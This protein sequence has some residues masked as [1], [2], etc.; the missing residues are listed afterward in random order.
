[1]THLTIEIRE[2]FKTNEL[3]NKSTNIRLYDFR[4]IIIASIRIL[5]TLIFKIKNDD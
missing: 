3:T 2:L 4:M 5:I 1:M